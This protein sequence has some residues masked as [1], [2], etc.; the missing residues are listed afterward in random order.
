MATPSNL[1]TWINGKKY[2]QDSNSW[3]LT[4]YSDTTFKPT[5]EHTQE[6]NALTPEWKTTYESTVRATA[7]QEY[8]PWQPTP[9][10]NYANDVA[11]QPAYSAQ[12]NPIGVSLWE[13][14][15][16][17]YSAQV[18]PVG[19]SLWE[20]PKIPQTTWTTQSPTST[21]P[22]KTTPTT[23]T[24][25]YS[26]WKP[27]Q[28]LD[29]NMAQNIAWELLDP[30]DKDP[31]RAERARNIIK[32]RN[33]SILAE[34]KNIEEKNKAI[35]DKEN[36]WITAKWEY[37]TNKAYISNYDDVNSKFNQIRD[38]Y[39]KSMLPDWSLP[40]WIAESIATKLWVTVDQ[41][42]DPTSLF[43]N[44]QYTEEWKN[45]FW[46]TKHEQ[47]LE[48][49]RINNDRAKAD[50]AENLRIQ[51]ENVQNQLDDVK[52]TMD[53]NIAWMTAQGAWSGAMNSSGYLTW[54][55]NVKRDWEKT[56]WRLREML[57]NIRSA[58]AKDVGRLTEDYV[59]SVS[60]AKSDFEQQLNDFKHNQWVALS[61]A[62]SKYD[63]SS[64]ELG[65]ALDEITAKYGANSADI[66]ARFLSNMNAI[67]SH[68]NNNIEL[69]K[70]AIEFADKQAEKRYSDY[71]ANP[72]MLSNTSYATIS[73]EVLDGKITDEQGVNLK[74]TVLNSIT[75]ALGKVAQVSED[76]LSVIRHLLDIGKTPIDVLAK[77]QSMDKFKDAV[78]PV[79]TIKVWNQTW[80][81]MSDKTKIIT[82]N[83]KQI[84]NLYT[85]NN[86]H[87]TVYS[88]G[89][90]TIEDVI[91]E[92]KDKNAQI[93][94]VN[95]QLYNADTG[96]WIQSP[97][98][99]S[100]SQWTTGGLDLRDKAKNYPTEASLKN[101]NPAWI[102]FNNTFAQRLEKAWIKYSKWTDR[103]ENE[104]GS[105]F[106]FPTVEEWLKAYNLLWDS[107]SYTNLTVWQALNRWG[108]W[109]LP[110]VDTTKKVSDLSES[111]KDQL[112]ISQIKKESPWMYR[113]L[114]SAWYFWPGG[115]DIPTQVTQTTSE[116]DPRATE[117]AQSIVDQKMTPTQSA[118][119]MKSQWLNQQDQA[120]V[121]KEASRIRNESKWKLT[122]DEQ[123]IVEWLKNYDLDPSAISRL[124]KDAKIKIL[125]A[126]FWDPN[127]DMKK[128]KTRQIF[129]NNWSQW[130]MNTN[131]N[132]I[133]TVTNH[134]TQLK[135][136]LE[137]LQNKDFKTF[138]RLWNASNT[139][140]WVSETN[141]A[142]AIAEAVASEMA[143]VY[144]WWNAAPTKDEIAA[145]KFR[146]STSLW[147]NQW[148]DLLKT[149][150]KLMY[151]KVESNAQAY[152]RT[153]GEKPENIFSD[154]WLQFLRENGV[155][156]SKDFDVPESQQ[157]TSPETSWLQDPDWIKQRNK[158]LGIP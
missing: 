9:S 23:V 97:S 45:K 63:P 105:Y 114:I 11:S 104:W 27:M 77:M 148:K 56:M 108:T 24:D 6:Y 53:K 20:P 2:Y 71:I 79:N 51:E 143:K 70:K 88:D 36:A 13:P 25:K 123:S 134:M 10:R 100:W 95:G 98:Q 72:A 37:D 130:P 22:Q 17:N 94:Q 47:S 29:E 156:V 121:D 67:D 59:K 48:D 144:K 3:N 132:A 30:N 4:Q 42:K 85:V 84:T 92:P 113:E 40:A 5:E 122:A 83:P 41:V 64:N 80:T 137:A 32:A 26:E 91:P 66:T 112:K 146:I 157:S 8:I 61:D 82:D 90:E 106:S 124:D 155:D 46:I 145:W 75:N 153:I 18:N 39:R 43:K 150:A 15:K 62:T 139:E 81:Y 131:N 141:D 50:T 151:G 103:P 142:G 93:L 107:P 152:K 127:Y 28:T 31:A 119:Y 49:A 87:H 136:A 33:Q 118:Y 35:K 111:E 140:F 158:A 19:V 86:K 78:V 138:N 128:Y 60:R 133:T 52:A 125:W 73:Q 109:N 34:N 135:P 14:P 7:G 65:K 110:W 117:I 120:L 57:N 68:I 96:E 147:E 58:N 149:L 99:F 89:T 154:E 55:N 129:M 76:D 116:I 44:F 16:P 21:T 102:T 69:N 1:Y 38:E 12:V 74:N 115:I 101:N 126:A 54:I